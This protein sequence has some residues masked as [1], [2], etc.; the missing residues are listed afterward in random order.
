MVIML[1]LNSSDRVAVRLGSCDRFCTD[2]SGRSGLVQ[3]HELLAHIV[4]HLLR[5]DPR[6]DVHRARRRQR[7]DHLDRPVRIARLREGV[8][9]GE[10]RERRNKQMKHAHPQ[11]LPANWITFPGTGRNPSGEWLHCRFVIGNASLGQRRADR[12]G[13]QLCANAL[14]SPKQKKGPMAFRPP[15][16]PS[17]QSSSAF[18]R[19]LIYQICI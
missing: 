10:Q 3:D 4:G 15:G 5:H 11:F 12:P 7:H 8:G 2:Q 19:V 16:E 9:A 18:Q 1:S 13:K 14:N 17:I 6:R